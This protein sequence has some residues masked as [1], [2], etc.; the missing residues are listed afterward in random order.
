MNKILRKKNIDELKINSIFKTVVRY[1]RNSISRPLFQ[2]NRAC[3]KHSYSNDGVIV[4]SIILSFTTYSIVRRRFIS[5]LYGRLI[6][7]LPSQKY[8]LEFNMHT[9]ILRA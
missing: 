2:S 3:F 4:I 1:N 8:H 9:N 5:T 6:K 7:T